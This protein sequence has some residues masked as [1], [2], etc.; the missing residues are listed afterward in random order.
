MKQVKVGVIGLG[1]RGLGLTWTMLA[2]NE[3]D[4]VAVCDSKKERAVAA[5]EKVKELR[6]HEVA[7]YEDYH[8]LL[9]DE[10]VD[11]VVICSCWDEHIRMAV[12]SMKAG[13]ITAMEVGGAPVCFP[14]FTRGKW[15]YRKRLD[16]MEFP[17]V[18][19]EN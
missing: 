17:E 5:N 3:A 14:D 4:I 13:K 19:K 1:Q 8:D 11:V 16:V 12:E 7:I 2:C 15:M 9:K 10:N 18:K 6:G